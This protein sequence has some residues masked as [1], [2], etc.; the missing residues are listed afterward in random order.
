[1]GEGEE[2]GNWREALSP[3][4]GREKRP[5]KK[6]TASWVLFLSVVISDSSGWCPGN[7]HIVGS[8]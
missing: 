5:P 7:W 8:Q 1:M 4:L 3:V 6:D 2:S